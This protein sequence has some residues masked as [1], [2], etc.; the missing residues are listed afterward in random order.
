MC[1][2]FALFDSPD[3]LAQAFDLSLDEARRVAASGP[4]Y[5]VAPS[6]A[7][8]GVTARPS[9]TGREVVLLR[10]GLVPHWA[11]SA[12]PAARMINARAET[13]ADKP[14]FRDPFRERRC[15]ILANGFY[16]WQKQPGGKQ[17]H[18]ICMPDRRP[19]AFAGLWDRWRRPPGEPVESCAIVTTVPNRTLEAIHDRMPVI[20]QPEDYDTWLDTSLDDRTPLEGLLRPCPEDRLISYPVSTLVN[21]PENDVPECV[22]PLD[23]PPL[24]LFDLN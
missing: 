9:G 2:R 24:D 13:V 18:F 12:E 7:V 17:P 15:L 19:F 10:W 22:E 3:D 4:R 20:L 23:E 11:Q 14:A 8:V 21:K 16:E 1:G 6:A 5:N